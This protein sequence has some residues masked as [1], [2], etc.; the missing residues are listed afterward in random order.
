M[1]RRKRKQF[2]GKL[3]PVDAIIREVFVKGKFGGSAQVS[4]LWNHWKDIVGEDVA[5]HCYPEKISC[6]KLYIKVDTPVWRQQL[7]LLKEEVAEKIN[8]SPA[9]IKIKK[10]LFR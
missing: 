5:G 6:G 4:E 9:N 2:D 7:D 1:K 10:I 3:E 8:D